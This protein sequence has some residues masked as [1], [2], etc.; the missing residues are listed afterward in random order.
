LLRR[1][2]YGALP[3]HG[4]ACAGKLVLPGDTYLVSFP[5]SGSTWL[6]Y[7][8]TSLR[9]GRTGHELKLTESIVP[10]IYR[11]GNPFLL[12]RR[13]PRLLKSHEPYT[14]AYRRVVYLVRDPRSVFVSL[15]WHQQRRR[16]RGEGA[17]YAGFLQEFLETGGRWGPWHHH[18]TGWLDAEDDRML[19]V[20]Y[21]DLVRDTAGCLGRIAG[22]TGIP[23]PR[24][25]LRSAVDEARL[26]RLREREREERWT[27]NLDS[28]RRDVPFFRSGRIDEWREELSP[29]Q[30]LGIETAFAGAMERAGYR[31]GRPVGGA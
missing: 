20:H 24:D 7:M 3:R 8:L 16:L 29:E 26:G 17:T 14:A 18:V 12:V 5:K 2:L 31:P 22:F 9:I 4:M 10:D 30:I 6:R 15:F 27:P 19:V 25:L 1:L 23:A 21:E 28:V 13:R 11:H